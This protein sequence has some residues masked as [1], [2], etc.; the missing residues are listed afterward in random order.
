MLYGAA[1]IGITVPVEMTAEPAQFLA[2]GA[3]SADVRANLGFKAFSSKKF[4]DAVETEIGNYI[5][6]KAVAIEANAAVQRT[7]IAASNTL[8]GWECYPTYFGSKRLYLPSADAVTYVPQTRNEGAFAQW[9]AFA[10]GLKS[11]AE[12]R[13]EKHF[14]LYVIGGYNE[15]SFNPA[16]DLTSQP[17]RPVDCV[18]TLREALVGVPNVDVM[19]HN[20][21]NAAEYYDDFFRT[22]HHWNIDGA[23]R[24][25]GEIADVLGL[26]QVDK[27]GTWEIPDYWFT[28]A[29]A[30]WGVDLLRERVFDCGNSFSELVATRPDG[31]VLR[32]DDHDSFW[33]APEL[34]RQYRFYD[35]YYG[36][37]GNCTITGGSG[38][39]S[40]L[41]VGNSYVGAIQRPLATSYRS[42]TVNSQLHPS[43]TVTA[44]LEEQMA[45]ADANDVIFVAN[46]GGFN[47]GGEYWDN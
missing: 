21:T 31:T 15:P 9:R 27:G 47:V 41:L 22:D 23:F 45:A 13:P 33:D 35:A 7:S 37:L 40:A 43:A 39:R 1:R 32:G 36:N 18:D 25:Y 28:G 38:D 2:G 16:Y 4:Q 6:G 34:G 24:A 30:R 17:L 20:Y 14:A 46:P 3:A 5:P 19:T 12:R 44:T 26:E 42:L 8:F 10:D 29:T 11:V